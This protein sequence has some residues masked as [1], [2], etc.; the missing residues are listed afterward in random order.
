M[1]LSEI[2]V[3]LVQDKRK[4]GLSYNKIA[5]LLNVTKSSVQ[6]VLNRKKVFRRKKMGRPTKIKKYDILRI[7][8]LSTA[9]QN[10]NE[11]VNSSKIIKQLEL[12]VSNN[13]V[14]RCLRR[15]GLKYRRISKSIQLIKRH[16]VE[17]ITYATQW[18]LNKMDWSRV[19]FTDEKRFSLDGPDNWCSYTSKGMV[20]LRCRRQM[21][22]SG[23]MVW[24]MMT[25]TGELF[26]RRLFGKQRS[27]EYK[28]LLTS[29][30]VPL[31]KQRFRN[32]YV[33][34]QDN[35]PIHVSME[36]KNYFQNNGI[37]TLE[38]PARSPDL[39]IIENM[40]KAI[41]DKVYDGKQ[42][43]NNNTLT[44]SLLN[45]V[46]EFNDSKKDFI[47]GLFDSIPSRLVEVLKLKGAITK[48]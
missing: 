43:Q 13:T 8:R 33:L 7:K 42:Y 32:N 18:L 24:G 9:L 30:A 44:Y 1:V 20:N 29:F 31:I 16:K 27:K 4:E 45:V 23:I 37:T 6:Y 10:R 11:K 12:N 19:V 17:R 38:W 40:W 14:Q 25:S 48:Y 36:M 39:N 46:K 15:I 21:G 3:K 26:V 41:S 47:K 5:S 28:E 35:C 2:L 22:G 34:Q